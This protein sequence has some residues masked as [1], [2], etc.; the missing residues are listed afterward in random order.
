MG[1]YIFF[2]VDLLYI[3]NIELIMYH[4]LEIIYNEIFSAYNC[5]FYFNIFIDE[6]SK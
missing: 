2:P 5:I 1:I 3:Y 4:Q 6:F